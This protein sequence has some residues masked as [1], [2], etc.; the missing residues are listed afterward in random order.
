MVNVEPGC[1][2]KLSQLYDSIMD[3]GMSHGLR[4]H[5]LGATDVCLS[6]MAQ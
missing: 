1:H 3:V 2:H 4:C 6:A 5:S